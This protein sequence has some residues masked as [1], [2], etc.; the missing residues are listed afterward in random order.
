MNTVKVSTTQHIDIEYDVAG[1]GER[2]AAYFI[3]LAIW[4]CIFLL[5]FFVIMATVIDSGFGGLYVIFGLF[6]LLFASYD[7]LCE[8]FLNGQSVGKRA[9]K[10]R[11]ISIDGK[12]PSLSQYLLRW[13][14]RLADITLTSG[15]GAIL[16]ISVT[17]RKQRIGDLVANTTVIKTEARV[18]L[19]AL[20]FSPAAVEDYQPVFPE[21]RQLSDAQVQLV[22]DVLENYKRSFNYDLI[23]SMANKVKE[24]IGVAPPAE[25]DDLK[26]LWR[27]VRDYTFLTSQG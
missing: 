4:I 22:H 23:L 19:T 17:D 16:S 20:A 1:V 2:I 21:V 11:V 3:D 27:V 18:P 13:V 10:I 26:F 24:S 9:M 15:V 7:L 5:F 6:Y 12:Q 14:F 8:I 25:M